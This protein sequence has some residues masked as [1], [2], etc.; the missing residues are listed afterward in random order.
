MTSP[1]LPA[2]CTVCRTAR[3]PEDTVC[4]GCGLVF[5]T[6]DTSATLDPASAITCPDCGRLLPPDALGCDSCGADVSQ[7]AA[8]LRFGQTLA[9]GRYTIQRRLAT[10]GMGAIYL[11][12]DHSAFDRTVV[13]KALLRGEDPHDQQALLAAKERFF[14][15]GRTLAALKHP[16]IPQIFAFFEERSQHYLVME[17]VEGSDLEQGLSRIDSQ[18][19][20]AVQGTPYPREQV[21]R[22]GIDLCRMLEYLAARQPHP[23]VHCDIKPA[24]VILDRHSGDLFL[25]DFGTAALRLQPAGGDPADGNSAA[26]GTPGYAAPEQYKGQS[27]P[28]SDVYA[29]AATLYHLATDDDPRAHPFS[30]PRL[31]DLEDLGLLLARALDREPSNRPS[32]ERLREQ[33]EH[34]LKHP[35]LPVSAPDGTSLRSAAAIVAW[36]EQHWDE[37]RDWV[38]QIPI[39]L[40]NNWHDHTLARALIERISHLRA[41]TGN[42]DSVLDGV[43]ALLDPQGF[44]AAKPQISVDRT[45]IDMNAMTGDRFYPSFTVQNIGRRHAYVTVNRD[46]LWMPLNAIEFWLPPGQRYQMNM[47]ID[48]GDLQNF[49][50]SHPGVRPREAV[51]LLVDGQKQ[52]QVRLA[53]LKLPKAPPKVADPIPV[54]PANFLMIALPVLLM[55]I[56]LLLWLLR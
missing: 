46:G 32:A 36:C 35:R 39:G 7:I 34:I 30:F 53:N 2:I 8:A 49:A 47:T 44:G 9:Q 33:L 18:S 27:E 48:M 28:R 56:V 43:L 23:L 41:T 5:S 24:N 14:Q 19:G 42:A 45:V 51:T 10:G 17:Y 37:A 26:Y 52:A 11:A 15:E 1:T 12:T 22:W 25:V 38:D 29:L 16:T 40:R 31:D 3:A 13:I 4:Q 21:L 6:Q 55:I 54:F 50:T 20:L